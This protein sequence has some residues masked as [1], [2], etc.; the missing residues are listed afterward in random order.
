MFQAALDKYIF[1]NPICHLYSWCISTHPVC[2]RDYVYNLFVQQAFFFFFF[3]LFQCTH[4]RS[5]FV[6]IH[7]F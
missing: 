5:A 3:N 6:V 7:E 4:G 1:T 2:I